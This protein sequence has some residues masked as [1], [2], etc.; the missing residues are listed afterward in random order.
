MK[1]VVYDS[2]RSFTITEV[3]TPQP[4]PGEVRVRVRQTGICGTDLQIGRAH[5]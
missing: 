3:P 1:A 2:P 4:G 5:V